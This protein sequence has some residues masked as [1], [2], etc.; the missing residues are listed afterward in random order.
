MSETLI[1]RVAAGALIKDAGVKSSINWAWT[2]GIAGLSLRILRQLW[3]G[4]WVGG[5][6]ELSSDSLRFD[7]NQINEAF[8]SG[9]VHVTIPLDTIQS[10][11]WRRG[12]RTG[13]IDVVSSDKTIGTFSFRVEERDTFIDRINEARAALKESKSPT[14]REV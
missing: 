9:R 3:G 11:A 8:A 12:M 2:A 4:V 5:F 7:P 10:V 1:A 14:S 13:V 6:A